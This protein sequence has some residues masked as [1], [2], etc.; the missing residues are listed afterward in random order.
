MNLPP[1]LSYKDTIYSIN[2]KK[3]STD[4]ELLNLLE[5]QTNTSIVVHYQI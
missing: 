1:N 4:E 3:V 5:N 2:V